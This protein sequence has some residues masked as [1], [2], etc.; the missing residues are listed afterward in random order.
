MSDSN[1]LLDTA[2]R[3]GLIAL[4]L[5]GG[6]ILT[7][8]ALRVLNGKPGQQAQAADQTNE[9]AGEAESPTLTPFDGGVNEFGQPTAAD[10]RQAAQDERDK[11]D[12]QA[13]RNMARAAFIQAAISLVGLLALMA[14]VKLARRTWVEA[15]RSADVAE[16]ADRAWLFVDFA[17]KSPIERSSPIHFA[18][19]V[20]FAMV[21][22][23]KT[24]A[25][26]KKVRIVMYW[27]PWFVAPVPPFD[28]VNSA[29][30]IAN[31]HLMGFRDEQGQEWPIDFQPEHIEALPLRPLPAE[32]TLEGGGRVNTIRGRLTWER[33]DLQTDQP[34][35][36]EERAKLNLSNFF[37]RIFVDY[38]DVRGTSR[39][40]EYYRA[41]DNSGTRVERLPEPIHSRYNRR[42]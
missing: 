31:V 16:A 26:I 4:I 28:P 1:R 6:V 3:I 19:E 38:E 8:M 27:F 2:I 25:I 32:I 24:P 9:K 7:P 11:S 15:K 42:T 34:D 30:G 13:Q 41:V 23:G 40:T 37:L 20:A 35:S 39:E 21:N 5:M 12:L 17:G 33:E 22:H 14:T 18:T 10:P 36:S 29:K